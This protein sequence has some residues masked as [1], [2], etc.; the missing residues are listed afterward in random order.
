MLFVRDSRS[1]VLDYTSVV[2]LRDVLR[3]AMK[4]KSSNP[5]LSKK[6]FEFDMGL[7]RNIN[8]GLKMSG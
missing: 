3:S 1:I 7:I 5:G 4:V 2:S 6:L 8:S